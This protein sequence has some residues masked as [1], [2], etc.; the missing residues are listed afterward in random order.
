MTFVNIKI[1]TIPYAA[2]T[3]AILLALQSGVLPT[4]GYSVLMALGSGVLKA[5]EQGVLMTLGYSVLMIQESGVLL[6]L[7]YPVLPFHKVMSRYEQ[8]VF[9]FVVPLHREK[10]PP[11]LSEGRKHTG[12]VNT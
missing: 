1:P 12:R 7:E 4:L 11:I 2:L 8:S 10:P 6:P 5:L 9:L 3:G